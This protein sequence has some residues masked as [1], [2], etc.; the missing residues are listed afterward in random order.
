MKTYI[1]PLADPH[2]D[3]ETVGGKGMSLAKLANSA[4]PVPD[5]FHVTTE[6][7]RLFVHANDLQAGILA[8]LQD[9]DT[10]RPAAL[11]TASAA[12]IELFAQA[13]I[14]AELAGAIVQAYA[15]LPGS[16][17]AVAVRSS[18]TAEDLPGASFAGQQDTYLNITGADKVLEA[19]C[20]CWA[21]LWTAR[22][23]GY[24]TR[25]NI[26]PESVA[27]AVV[28]QLLVNAEAA[29]ILFTANPLNGDR[30][31]IVINA[32]WGLGEAIVGGLVTPDTLILSK[33]E[34]KIVQRDTAEKMVMTVRTPSGT[35][36]QPVP[37]SL[38]KVPALSDELASRLRR[39][40]G[41][42][43]GPGGRE[44]CHCSGPPG[45]GT[46]RK[47]AAV[48]TTRSKRRLY[49]HQRCRSAARAAQP[50]VRIFGN[51]NISQANATAGGA[52]DP[53]QAGFSC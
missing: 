44:I 13:E 17:P 40:D 24:R 19:T 4:L 29:G 51:P 50:I 5:G 21:S 39:A 1:L 53:L 22:A 20:K 38:R 32:A 45:N 2:A 23:I 6:A 31:Q 27:L 10:S 8:A 3:L 46:A 25:Q 7:Y 26:P 49:A 18:A 12:I 9:V 33:P 16:N 11:E 15:T 34:G 41:H 48:D 14:P 47:A 43:M 37:D 52:P 36:E 42:R 28:V 35:T 30:D